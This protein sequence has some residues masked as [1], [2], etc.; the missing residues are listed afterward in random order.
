MSG[1]TIGMSPFEVVHG[2]KPKKPLDL[3]PMSLH[4]KMS[5]S[6]EYFAR[7]IQDWHVEITKQIQASDVQY[8]LQDDLYRWH[9]EFNVENYVLIRIRP[10]RFS[11]GTNWK[12]HARSARPFKVLQRVGPNAY[13]FYLPHDFGISSTFN[14]EDLVAYHKPLSIPNDPF[15]IPLNS[16]PN[17]PIETYIL[18]TLTSA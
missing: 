12:L 17:D 3:F 11:L 7:R 16:L 18:F 15:E 4:A 13:I 10:E 1:A 9:N 14:I 8:K 6:I 2:Y 5:K